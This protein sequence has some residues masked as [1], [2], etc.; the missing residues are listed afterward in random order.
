MQCEEA[1]NEFTSYLTDALEES[2]RANV[3][4]HLLSCA[5]CGDEFES[6]MK[7]WTRLGAIPAEE[8]RVDQR[9]RFDAMLEVYQ[10]GIVDAPAPRRSW[11]VWVRQWLPRQPVFQFAIGLA[12]LVVGVIAGRSYPA[13]V[14]SNAEMNQLRTELHSL[15]EMV[16]LSLLQQQSASERLKGV[17]WSYRIEQPGDQVRSALLDTLMH[18]ANVN[19]RL[20]A[21]DALRQFGQDQ[22]VRRGLVEALERQNSALVQIAMI[23]LVVELRETQ[24]LNALR[25]LANDQNLNEAVRQRAEWGLN[26]LS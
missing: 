17:S 11:S 20:A 7:V 23:D 14:Q 1:R 10:Q 2:I 12:L 13:P 3:S 24:S 22:Q 25:K 18:D 4:R 19:V 8:P 15:H 5:T 6:L 16:A 21:V 26:Q 9:A